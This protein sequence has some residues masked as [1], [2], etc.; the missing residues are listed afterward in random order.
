[1]YSIVT[2]RVVILF[3]FFFLPGILTIRRFFEQV[4]SYWPNYNPK[5]VVIMSTSW[6]HEWKPLSRLRHEDVARVR[7]RCNSENH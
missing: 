4:E 2:T 7:A 1:M 5:T 6:V 3:L